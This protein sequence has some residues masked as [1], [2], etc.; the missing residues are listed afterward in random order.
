MQDNI[1]IGANAV[2]NKNFTEENIAI[3]GIPAKKISNNGALEWN[4][5]NKDNERDN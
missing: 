5:N 4:K 2:V 1:A 3:A